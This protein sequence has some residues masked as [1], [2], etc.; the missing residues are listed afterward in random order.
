MSTIAAGL[1]QCGCGEKTRIAKSNH[2]ASGHI[3]GEP[4]RFIKY[5]HPIRQRRGP[6]NP[7]WKGGREVNDQGYVLV[8]APGHPRAHRNKVREHILIAEEALGKPLPPEAVVHHPN[9]DPTD[10]RHE[11]LVICQDQGYHKLLHQRIRAFRASGNPNWMKCHYCQT[12]DDPKNMVVHPR[13]RA[14]R[15]RACHAKAELARFHSKKG[16]AACD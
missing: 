15:H 14:A 11:N 8:H 6:D 7:H 4:V 10:N 3:K 1:C 13:R 2:R 5:H 12:Y 16:E 9:E